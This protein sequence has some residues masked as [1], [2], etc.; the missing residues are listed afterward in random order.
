MLVGLNY[1]WMNY[2]WDFGVPPPGWRAAESWQSEIREQLPR[3]RELGIRAVR[4]FILA[5]GMSL[6]RP[7]PDPI[8]DLDWRMDEVAAPEAALLDDF[9]CMLSCFSPDVQVLPV[10]LDFPCAF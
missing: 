10:V 8:W 4:W 7:Q 9:E 6:S 5:D 3:W 1:P 2:G